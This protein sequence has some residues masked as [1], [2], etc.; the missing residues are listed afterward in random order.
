MRARQQ[1]ATWG[2]TPEI[3]AFRT[4]YSNALR[5]TP[6]R[7]LFPAFGTRGLRAQKFLKA[8]IRAVG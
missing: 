5:C 3:P 7:V 4:G 6:G 8:P 2:L 1:L